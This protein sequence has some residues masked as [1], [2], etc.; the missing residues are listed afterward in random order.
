MAGNPITLDVLKRSVEAAGGTVRAV[1]S[2]R[3]Y[4]TVEGADGELVFNASAATEDEAAAAVAEGIAGRRVQLA[5]QVGW[6]GNA[7]MVM[8]WLRADPSLEIKLEQPRIVVD[9]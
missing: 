5:R 9:P 1:V 3:A 8:E 4:V 2:D 6:I 7:E